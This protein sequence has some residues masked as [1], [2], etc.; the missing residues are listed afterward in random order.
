LTVN[1]NPGF[2]VDATENG[3]AALWYAREAARDSRQPDESRLRAAAARLSDLGRPGVVG[4][5]F[6]HFS[7]ALLKA[8]QKLSVKAALSGDE[9]IVLP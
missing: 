7:K 2:V 9:G 1:N 3:N 5:E 4:L 8:L 6:G